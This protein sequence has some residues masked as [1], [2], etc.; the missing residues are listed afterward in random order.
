M[1]A[2]QEIDSKVEM[3]NKLMM[4]VRILKEE[5]PEHTC[6][7]RSEPGSVLNAYREGD[8]TFEHAKDMIENMA[9]SEKARQA[10]DM[11]GITKMVADMYKSRTRSEIWDV[12]YHTE[13]GGE[14]I[15]LNQAM[16]CMNDAEVTDWFPK[17]YTEY[18]MKQLNL[19]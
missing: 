4:D 7:M 8:I 16:V 5:H 3:I 11:D 15:E 17:I 12:L 14:S 18:M 1:R 6:I 13:F 19:L 10:L 9:C 2:K